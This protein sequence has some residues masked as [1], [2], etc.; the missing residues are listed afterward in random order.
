MFLTNI[1]KIIEYRTRCF[2]NWFQK[3][4]RKTA[5]ATGEFIGNK[6]ADKIV[7]T[8]PVIDKNSRNIDEII[9]PPE[10]IEKTIK[11]IKTNIIKW[12]TIKHLS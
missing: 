11:R 3:S 4:S 7:K 6:T 5:E 12:N 10:K 8:K 1:E 2:K 9:F